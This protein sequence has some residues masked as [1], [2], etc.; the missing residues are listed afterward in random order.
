MHNP[1]HH[2][3][4]CSI[5]FFPSLPGDSVLLETHLLATQD[6]ELQHLCRFC[7]PRIKQTPK[8]VSRGPLLSPE[9][10][11]LR[12]CCKP[13]RHQLW[14]ASGRGPR[15]EGGQR[16]PCLHWMGWEVSCCYARIRFNTDSSWVPGAPCSHC[17]DWPSTFP[18]GTQGSCWMGA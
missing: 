8:V 17:P 2:G 3:G 15:G 11:P 4:N 10:Q 18:L 14:V 6:A 7:G 5:S 13:Q 12:L 16:K 1:G 9:S